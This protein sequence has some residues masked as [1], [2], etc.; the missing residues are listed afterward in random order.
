M[1]DAL[2]EHRQGLRSLDRL[3]RRVVVAA[4]LSGAG[5]AALLY[6][7]RDYITNFPHSL[8]LFVA[9][10]AVLAACLASFSVVERLRSPVGTLTRSYSITEEGVR[11]PRFKE[12]IPW[13]HVA[14]HA[15][16][17]GPDDALLL[18]LDTGTLR[19]EVKVPLP[20]GDV[21][22]KVLTEFSRRARRRPPSDEALKSWP[23]WPLSR[24]ETNVLGL[25]SLLLG[26]TIGALVPIHDLAGVGR[27]GLFAAFLVGP[28]TVV[29]AGSKIRLA[30]RRPRALLFH[31]LVFN[32]VCGAAALLVSLV[33]GFR[34]FTP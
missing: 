29:L 26:V 23:Q 31:A 25:V 17:P 32:M 20:G 19:G 4:S 24:T 28:M 11:V 9:C 18:Y 1:V 30:L 3:V 14:H 34:R 10:V 15:V 7:L 12:R 13:A 8:L 6:Y 27:L 22:S 5:G 21:R 2:V 16:E 33:V